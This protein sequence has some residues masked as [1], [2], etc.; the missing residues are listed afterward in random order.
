MDLLEEGLG[1]IIDSGDEYAPQGDLSPIELAVR[2]W[3]DTL[4][5]YAALRLSRHNFK[6]ACI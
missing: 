3:H 6:G 5:A 1:E 4:P 2:A